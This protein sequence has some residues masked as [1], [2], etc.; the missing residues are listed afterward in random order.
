MCLPASLN[1]AS[2]ACNLRYSVKDE[3][4]KTLEC[5]TIDEEEERVSRQQIEEDIRIYGGRPKPPDAVEPDGG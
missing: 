1:E 2:N 3:L 4:D 5:I